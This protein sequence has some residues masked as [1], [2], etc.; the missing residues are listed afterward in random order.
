MWVLAMLEC[1]TGLSP[2]QFERY[3]AAQTN[4]LADLLEAGWVREAY[5]RTD[6]PGGVLLLECCSLAE[7][8]QIVTML[9]LSKAGLVKTTFVP[10]RP[11]SAL[12][13]TC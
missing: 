7:A 8:Q 3:T 9:P 1:V 5:C 6:Q 11:W 12:K 10:L 4:N 2:E 13:R